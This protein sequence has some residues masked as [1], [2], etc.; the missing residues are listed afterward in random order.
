MLTRTRPCCGDDRATATMSAM[1]S[2]PCDPASIHPV[3]PSRSTMP[4]PSA[5]R[6]VWVWI[7]IKPGTTSLPRA[8]MVSAASAAM[9]GSTAAM[10][11]PEIA[12]SRI[13]SS[14]R[15]I[16]DPP[17]LDEQVVFRRLRRRM[18][19]GRARKSPR[20]RRLLTGT[21]AGSPSSPPEMDPSWSLRH[22]RT[23]QQRR[24]STA[25]VRGDQGRNRRVRD[26]NSGGSW[27]TMV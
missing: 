20:R 23:R 9:L 1:R 13:A 15:R 27:H 6:P 19:S 25:L 21:D 26:G 14:R 16:D 3:T 17:A 12:T 7:S 4:G 18:L 22:V 2:A 5:E 10:R 8:S 11:P 24:E